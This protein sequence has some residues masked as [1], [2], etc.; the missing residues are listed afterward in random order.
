MDL[1]G[2]RMIASKHVFIIGGTGQIGL[3]A[4]DCFL[5]VGWSVTAAHRG[6]GSL[7]RYLRDD[8]CNTVALDRDEAGALKHA[9]PYGADVVID[10]VAYDQSHANQLLEIQS[11]V[12]ALVVIS[13]ASVY[14][15]EHGRT[16]DEA[17][18]PDEYPDLPVPV[19]ET[20]RT[21]M[22]G[23]ETY[24][25]RKVALEQTLLDKASIP[26][27]VLRPGAVYGIGSRHPRE[28]WFLKRALDGRKSVPLAYEGLSRFHASSSK[29]IAELARLAAE[30]SFHGILN[31]GDPE[32]LTVFEIGETIAD[33]VGHQW[34][35]VPIPHGRER[36]SVG[37]TPWSVPKPF[38]LDMRA[39]A[40]LGYHAVTTYQ[41]QMPSYCAWLSAQARAQP[42]R[43]AFPILAR[44]P[45]SDLF[46]Y[47]AE[48][49][50]MKTFAKR[51]RR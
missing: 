6:G 22:P 12:G 11:Q 16:L 38:V 18:S 42:W 9:L 45:A 26:V 31:A 20:Q 49:E 7:S 14:M 44:Y 1:T 47:V 51:W 24:S 43:Q 32:C 48:D 29:N 21:V 33:A 37:M 13:S 34:R 17:K 35:L 15:D 41:G 30:R 50:F 10:C 2:E 5:T 28:W 19:P 25:T 36:D 3:A 23:P 27:T 46:D 4:I 39:A 8:R 40:A